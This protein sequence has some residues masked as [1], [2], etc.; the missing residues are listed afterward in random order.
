MT[1]SRLSA[2]FAGM[3]LAAC[4]STQ[5]TSEWRDEGY[6]G[7]PLKKLMVI[8]VG[9]DGRVRR[10]VE[11]EFVTKLQARGTEAIASYQLFPSEDKMSREAV[12][13][14]V[15]ELEAQAIL[16]TRMLGH[17]TETV[18]YPGSTR[19]EEVPSGGR[20]HRYYSRS[21]EV[22]HTPPR[23]V[24]Y[25]VATLESEVFEAHTDRL[26]WAATFRTT[27]DESES[28]NQAVASFVSQALKS[29]RKNDLID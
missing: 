29:L 20:W 9:I 24:R 6:T 5:L 2:V 22:T 27:V 19:I 13:E 12:E 26:L 16:V 15:R 10:L 7:G 23:T 28:R 11:D 14:K 8:G 3:L 4:A 21:W 17:E 1:F 25:D 18:E